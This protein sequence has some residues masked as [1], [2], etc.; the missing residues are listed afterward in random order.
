MEAY[1]DRH[2]VG[3]M[4]VGG[5]LMVSVPLLISY[6]WTASGNYQPFLEMMY[7]TLGF[8]LNLTAGGL[9]LDHYSH[10]HDETGIALGVRLTFIDS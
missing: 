1:E 8:G 10:K 5:M 6:I 3:L 4:A 7:N 9:A 2:N